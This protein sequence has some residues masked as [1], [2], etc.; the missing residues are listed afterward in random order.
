MTS[1]WHEIL[2]ELVDKMIPDSKE[3]S[4]EFFYHPFVASIDLPHQCLV[5]SYNILSSSCDLNQCIKRVPWL[6]LQYRIPIRN[7]SWTKKSAKTRWFIISISI[8][9]F[10]FKVSFRYLCCKSWHWCWLVILIL[11][12][13]TNPYLSFMTIKLMFQLFVL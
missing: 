11:R 9:F 13:I 7:S 1:S 6:L 3:H 4:L 8:T 2:D 5:D 12:I 10:L